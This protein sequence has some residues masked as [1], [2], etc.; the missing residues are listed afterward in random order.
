MNINNKILEAL[1]DIFLRIFLKIIPKIDRES[2][3]E[4]GK[5]KNSICIVEDAYEFLVQEPKQEL[6]KKRF[7]NSAGLRKVDCFFGIKLID[8]RLIGPY[9]IPVTRLG[10]IILEPISK[11]SLI[12]VFKFT[13]KKIGLIGFVKQ[14]FLAICPYFESNSF[15]EVGAHL[16]CR[17]SRGININGEF[18]LSPVFGHWLCEQLPQLRG[19]EAVV[20]K[21]NFDNCKLVINKS[22]DEWQIDSLKLM[23]YQKDNIICMDSDGLR[24][25]QL[26]L[27]SLRATKSRGMEFDP[28]ARQWAAKRLQSNYKQ[29]D[30][31][32]DSAKTKIALFRQEVLSRRIKNIDEVREVLKINNFIEI[33]I[34]NQNLF[35]SAKN[36]VN[37]HY[38][39]Y[40]LGGG[41]SR[42]MFSKNLKEVIEIY[43]CDQDQTDVNF[44]LASEMGAK[45]NCIAAGKLPLS[46]LSENKKSAIYRDE[47]KNEWHVPR[48]ELL[49]ILSAK[50]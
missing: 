14:Y 23:G 7:K 19:V 12:H 31:T 39:L 36:F 16:I 37:A 50:E 21:N 13:I 38:L 42:I 33:D 26:I 5:K 28:K 47:E 32:H 30:F 49:D 22:P 18:H 17:A 27:S 40:T 41:V 34:T 46:V 11:R 6:A 8:V 1:N 15:L 29:Q 35:D 9:G 10:Q 48:K 43:S 20:L 24:V 45:Y 25:G 2:L 4:F 3:I 44:L